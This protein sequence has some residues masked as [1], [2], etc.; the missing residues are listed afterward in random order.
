MD[1]KFGQPNHV[2]TLSHL[3][4]WPEFSGHCLPFAGHQSQ[5]LKQATK[6]FLRAKIKEARNIS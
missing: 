4:I 6:A 5:G 1:M 2:A 3:L